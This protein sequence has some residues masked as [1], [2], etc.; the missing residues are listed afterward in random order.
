MRWPVGPYQIIERHDQF[1]VRRGRT[2]LSMHSTYF[3]AEE[4]ALRRWLGQQ[5]EGQ[6]KDVETNYEPRTRFPNT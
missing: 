1:Q 2:I 5:Y 6:D 4:A 3:E